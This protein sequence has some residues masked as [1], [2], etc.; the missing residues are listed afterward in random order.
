MPP[1][2]RAVPNYKLFRRSHLPGGGAEVLAMGT[3]RQMRSALHKR[4]E[5]LDPLIEEGIYRLLTPILLG[6]TPSTVALDYWIEGPD[7][8]VRTSA[9]ERLRRPR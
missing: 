3:L 5:G 2:L 7:G 9:P 1:L 6:T 4:L 8:V